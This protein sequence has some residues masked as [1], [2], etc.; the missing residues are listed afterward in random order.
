MFLSLLNK[1]CEF[2]GSAKKQD[3]KLTIKQILL[4]YATFQ[5]SVPRRRYDNIHDDSL[6]LCFQNNLLLSVNSAAEEMQK[7]S[8]Q[9]CYLR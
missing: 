4:F 5:Y 6:F 3:F 9:R 1:S 7:D 2:G 8:D